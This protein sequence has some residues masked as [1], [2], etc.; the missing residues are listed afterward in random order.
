MSL[1]HLNHSRALAAFP[2]FGG[3]PTLPATLE[4]HHGLQNASDDGF[5]LRLLRSFHTSSSRLKNLHLLWCIF[6]LP[7][8]LAARPQSAPVEGVSNGIF[9]IQ[10]L[11]PIPE[12]TREALAEKPPVESGSFRKS[13]L[14]ELTKLDPSIKLDIRY[15]GTNNFLSTPV[16]SQARAFLQRPAAEAL[17]RANKKLAPLGYGLIIHDG[18]RPWYVTKVFWDATPADKH[19]FVAD[20]AQGSKHNR[21]CAVDLSMYDLKT[22]KEVEMPSVYDEMTPRAFT[23]YPGGTDA[24]RKRREVLRDAMQA[25]GFVVNPREWW[26]FDYKDW[27]KYPIGNQ[28]FEDLVNSR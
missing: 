6:L 20:P 16:Y 13:D 11:H 25:E 18:Y 12:L 5:N 23:D 14:V 28:R 3:T 26:H 1:N 2:A 8:L 9:R 21:G 15:A 4:A 17:V 19:I 7:A 10:P 24:E 22:G 27:Q